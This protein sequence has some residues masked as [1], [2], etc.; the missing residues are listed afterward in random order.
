MPHN[1]PYQTY[2]DP[3]DDPARK[4]QQPFRAA[5]H[6]LGKL[7]TTGGKAAVSGLQRL[8]TAMNRGTQDILTG[9]MSQF[10][11][12]IG[13]SA[14]G[15]PY[16]LGRAR[17][18]TG[19]TAV[20]GLGDIDLPTSEFSDIPRND[21]DIL[22]RA[23]RITQRPQ[24]SF[25]AG[26]VA[27]QP[28]VPIQRDPI[29]EATFRTPRSPLS[30][31]TPERAASILTGGGSER[32]VT[33]APIPPSLDEMFRLASR[34][35]GPVMGKPQFPT[36]YDPA[37]QKMVAAGPEQVAFTGVA[38]GANE[39]WKQRLGEEV[40]AQEFQTKLGRGKEAAYAEAGLGGFA[41]PMEAAEAARAAEAFK[42]EAPV[43][44]QDVA[45]KYDVEA[46]RI[47]SGGA[48]DVARE[49]ASQYEGLLNMF[50]AATQGGQDVSRF[51]LPGGGS[52]SFRGQEQIPVAIQRDV[53]AAKEN[54]ARVRQQW[55][56][57]SGTETVASDQLKAALSTALASVP[58]D[59][60]DKSALLDAF[61]DPENAGRSLDEIFD[62]SQM[63]P[64]ELRIITN[65]VTLVG[66]F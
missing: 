47:R 28:M 44:A 58:I 20:S 29:N 37:S 3:F 11:G 10:S 59:P 39:Y 40:G 1:D 66:G 46:E 56:F 60:A 36:R 63:T 6:S 7:P 45:G 21:P 65:F 62:V 32:N 27:S 19:T 22:A 13:G 23:D 51:S 49:K 33:D 31:E 41:S 38:P 15:S 43:R 52:M 25:Q 24:A 35:E 53:T 14:S 5:L 54:L 16:D 34:S 55:S 57:G 48:L 9:N 30:V 42:V 4:R 18:A 17:A 2:Q 64:D 26:P 50:N 61:L 8:D 12:G